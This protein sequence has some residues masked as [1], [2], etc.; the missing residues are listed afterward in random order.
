MLN[1]DPN[2]VAAADFYD[3]LIAVHRDLSAEQS[4][5]VNAKLI[6]LLANHIGDPAV[7]RQAMVKAREGVTP[8]AASATWS[9]T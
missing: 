8:A 4:R 6:L 3:A 9:S 1:T 7:P 5:L 2:V